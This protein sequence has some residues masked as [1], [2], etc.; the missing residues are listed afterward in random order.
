[1][2]ALASQES[3]HKDVAMQPQNTKI[4]SWD[5][6]DVHN[7]VDHYSELS[8]SEQVIMIIIIIIII[9]E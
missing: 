9:I 4:F 7:F 5:Q 2:H 6:N 3:G 1:M 8:V